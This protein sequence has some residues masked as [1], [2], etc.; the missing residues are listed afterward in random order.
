MPQRIGEDHKDFHDVY[1]GKKRKALKKY[2][3][4]GTIFRLRPKDG[5]VIPVTIGKI[6]IPHIVYGEPEDGVG[7]GPGKPGDVIKKDKEKGD[8]GNQAGQGEQEGVEIAV[9]MDEVLKELGDE[10]K[11][12]KMQPKPNQTYE[13]IEIKYNDIS[14]YGPESLR[15]NRRTL[16][17]ALKRMCSTGDINKLHK[18]PG[19]AE[20]VKLITPINS[21]KRYRQYREIK[22]PASNAVIFFARDGSASMDQY[23]C[24]IVSDMA[25][26]MD[27]WIRKFYERVDRC[28]IW[29][30]MIAQEVS[31]NKFYRYRYG[32]GTTCSSALKLIAKQFDNRYPP[33]KWNI[34][35]F[36]FTDGENWDNDNEVF[37]KIIQ[38]QFPANK[39]NFVGIT[40][41]MAS[42]YQGSLKEFVDKKLGSVENVRTTQ[43]GADENGYG[44]QLA[45]E[46]R[47]QQVKKAICDLLGANKVK[48]GGI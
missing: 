8:G 19:F 1:A 25:W 6:D 14:M 33:E 3:N 30:D 36:Y 2:I 5:K 29:H 10:L 20:P 27:A 45:D 13:D 48:A 15:H 24:D 46:D 41:V 17:Q 38:E 40:Q 37:C 18:I 7:R 39:V 43:V 22:I 26:W 9:D 44:V 34:Y 28:Y 31:E 32:G 42:Q 47:D 11:L 35:V 21:D 16:M 12:P 23:K 4:N